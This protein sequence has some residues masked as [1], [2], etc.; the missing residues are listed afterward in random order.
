MKKKKKLLNK[1]EFYFE[2][3]LWYKFWQWIYIHIMVWRSVHCSMDSLYSSQSFYPS[4]L[5][6]CDSAGLV[7]SDFSFIS[8]VMGGVSKGSA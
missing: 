2:N 6:S 7:S 8:S 4:I 1:I 5:T 3:L